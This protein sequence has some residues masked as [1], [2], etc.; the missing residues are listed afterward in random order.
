M[1][2]HEICETQYTRDE[3][4]KLDWDDLTMMAYGVKKW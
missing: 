3:L 4:L 1:R 2:F